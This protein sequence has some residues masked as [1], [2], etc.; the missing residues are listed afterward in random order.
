MNG[1]LERIVQTLEGM[2]RACILDFLDSWYRLVKLMELLY[3]NSYH[4]GIVMAPFEALYGRKCRSLLYW[5]E[6][7]EK[8][9]T[10]LDL[11]E[12]TLE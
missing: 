3:N 1:Q 2:L 5:D 10:G 7:S 8:L 4:S 11:V 6:V 12:R 9:I